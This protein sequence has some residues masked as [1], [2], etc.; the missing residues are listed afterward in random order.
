MAQV[1]EGNNGDG[2]SPI[3]ACFFTSNTPVTP[4]VITDPEVIPLK[5]TFIMI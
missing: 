5:Q 3:P 4:A 2:T 1:L